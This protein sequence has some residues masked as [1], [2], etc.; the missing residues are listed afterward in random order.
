MNKILVIFTGGTIGSSVADGFISPDSETKHLIVSKYK[1]VT[2][3]SE[4]EL[5]A[6]TPYTTLSE[7]LSAT[8][9]NLLCDCVLNNIDDGYDGIIVTHGTDTLQY[10]ASVLSY[11]LQ[12]TELPVVLVSAAYPL[13]DEKSNGL[14]NFIAA[15]EFIKAKAGKGVFV[16]YKNSDVEKTNIHIGTRVIAHQEGAANIYSI[17]EKPYA[18]Y[19]NNEILLNERFNTSEIGEGIGRV[20]FTDYPD[21]LMVECRPGEKYNYDPEEAKAIIIVPYHSGTINTKELKLIELCNKA[22]EKDIPVFLVNA[23]GGIGYESTQ[24]YDDM[25]LEVLPFCSKIAIYMK[26]WIALSLEKP[27]RDF[28]KKP[29]AQ[30]F[31]E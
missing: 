16:S 2:K 23:R 27:V 28:V 22:R 25:G 8:E 11:V 12:G 3:D 17:D 13:E 20:R 6:T 10:T 9:L 29:I 31:C 24:V 7:Y 19:E 4:T 5:I 14:A 18:F 21:I 30:E 26:C 1:E 15:V